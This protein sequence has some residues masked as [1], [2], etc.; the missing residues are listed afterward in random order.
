MSSAQCIDYICEICNFIQV[1]SI[2]NSIFDAFTLLEDHVI[3]S[4]IS[5]KNKQCKVTDVFK[6]N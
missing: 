1:S 4:Q 6:A 2:S 3:Q 5:R